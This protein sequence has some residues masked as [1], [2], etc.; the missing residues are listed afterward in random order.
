[1]PSPSRS[2]ILALMI[3]GLTGLSLAT[4]ACAP[5][6]IGAGAGVGVAA[7]QERGFSTAMSDTRIRAE[8]NHLWI[9]ESEEL[10]SRVQLQVQEGRVLLSGAMPDPQTRVDAVRL[11]WQVPGVKEVINEIEVDDETTLTDQTRDVW[12]S[13]R[14]KTRLL[15]DSEVASIN[16]SIEVVNQSIFLIGIAQD[17]T[18]LD[19]VISHAK[20]LSYVRRVVSYVRL[21]D[22]A[23]A[24]S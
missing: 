24:A 11:A 12:I 15:G 2:P 9:Q 17:Q 10:Y 21:K 22:P 8:I 5:V 23:P 3:A 20:N 7:A 6:L 18:E 14:L 4:T 16:Y 1:M 19:R 13:T